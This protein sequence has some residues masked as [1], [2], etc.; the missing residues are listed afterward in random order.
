MPPTPAELAPIE[1]RGRRTRTVRSE[2]AT[3]ALMVIRPSLPRRALPVVLA[4]LMCI[5]TAPAQK[6]RRPKPPSEWSRFEAGLQVAVGKSDWMVRT[7]LGKDELEK[8]AARIAE[9]QPFYA[10]H[11]DTRLPKGWTFTL[12][13]DMGQFNSYARET[14]RGRLAV[15][16][17]CLRSRKEVVVCN[18]KRYGWEAT[19]SHEFAHAYYDC[20]GPIWLREGVASL[21]EVAERDGKEMKIPVNPPRRRGL[22]VYQKKGHY[23]SIQHLLRGEKE[24]DKYG[25]SYEHGWSLHYFLYC[26]DAKKYRAFLTAVRTGTKRDLSA[27][28]EKHFG[29]APEALDTEWK[30]FVAGL[31]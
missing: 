16:G 26:R 15:Q 9:L 3:L 17:Q 10:K 31:K 13:A 8:A 2:S 5:G 12:L 30:E 25:Y 24:P 11:F 14:T 27:Q 7:T 28:V 6:G 1:R 23:L 21:V 20:N 19:L 22:A 29:K 18:S 4:L